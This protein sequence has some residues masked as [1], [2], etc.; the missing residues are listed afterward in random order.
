MVFKNCQIQKNKFSNKLEVVLRG[1]TKIEPSS[2]EFEIPDMKTVGSPLIQLCDLSNYVEYDKV[3]VKVKVI[4]VFDPQTV[5]NGKIKQEIIIA[6]E[7]GK[8]VLTLWE[9]Y[10]NVLCLE[11]SYQLSRITVKVFMGKH[12]LSIPASGSTIEDVSDVEDLDI[13]SDISEDEDQY[14]TEVSVAGVQHLDT[15][16]TCIN[17]KKPVEATTEKTGKCSSCN[18]VQLLST[19]KLSAKLF[20]KAKSDVSSIALRANTNAIKLITN[21]Q[22]SIENDDLIFAEP[23]DVSYNKFNTI[24]AVIRR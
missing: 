2:F 4:K 18:T 16:Y 11:K 12:Q 24:T 1:N 6:D 22:S 20:I 5:S 14:L 21:K 23:F 13:D 3:T 9:S 10:V 15:I 19:P 17:C 7:T 8:C